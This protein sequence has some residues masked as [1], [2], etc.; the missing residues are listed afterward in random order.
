MATQNKKGTEFESHFWLI[1]KFSLRKINQQKSSGFYIFFQ[2]L[3]R[4]ELVQLVRTKYNF[5]LR[6]ELKAGLPKESGADLVEQL[7]NPPTEGEKLQQPVEE[8]VNFC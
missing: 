6:N 1:M 4:R 7:F 8:G 2:I 5:D 3:Q